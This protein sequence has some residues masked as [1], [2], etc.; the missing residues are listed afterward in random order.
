MEWKKGETRDFSV[1]GGIGG[2]R[3]LR[4]PKGTKKKI[5]RQRKWDP[6]EKHNREDMKGRA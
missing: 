4:Q 3:K 1:E 2:W 6:E 5:D